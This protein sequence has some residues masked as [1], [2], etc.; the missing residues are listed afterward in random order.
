MR[1]LIALA[2]LALAACRQT[3]PQPEAVVKY[4]V[5]VKAGAMD[6]ILVKDYAPS[7]S[8]VVP[9]S[10]IAKARFPVIDVHSHASMSSIKSRADVDAWVKIMDE[11][12]VEFSVVF[13][14]ADR[15]G[16][17]RQAELFS[18]Y[19]KRFQLWYTPSAESLPGNAI[20]ELERAHS[21]GARGVGEITD[22]G[23]GV[24]ANE[25]SAKP[26]AQR[27]RFNDPRMDP[28]WKRCGE[29]NMPVNIHLA[30]H[31]SCWRPLDRHQERSPDFQAFNLY[32]KDVPSYD[33]LLAMRASLLDRNPKTTFIFCHF[34]NQGN[35]TAALS[36]MLDRH[37]NMY[38]DISARDYEIGRQPHTM[39]AFLQKHKD[40]IM[41]GTD[42]GRDHDMYRMWW[43]LLESPDE[44]IQGRAGWPYYGLQLD[45]ATLR[46]L[47]RDTARK[48]LRLP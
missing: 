21:K 46:S 41:F 19:P 30:D 11:T 29:L 15:A 38:L 48:V 9:K 6:S 23:W 32:G 5:P 39:R 14:D 2:A 16:F 27:L 12:G 7:S 1:T 45:D 43:R 34:S 37:P 25:K 35:D 13:T 18:A 36:R 20:A 40:R 42:M 17:D 47:Y 3:P 31:P 33:E 24:E 22:K 10:D 44:S 28:F 4:G 8:L 26:R